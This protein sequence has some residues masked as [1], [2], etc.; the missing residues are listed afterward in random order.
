MQV[1]IVNVNKNVTVN[2]GPNAGN[3][4]NNVIVETNIA[5]V[6]AQDVVEISNQA[7]QA[8]QTNQVNRANRFSADISRMREIWTEHDREVQNFRRL[9]Q[10]L[11]G[12]QAE[13]A[14]NAWGNWNFNNPNDMVEISAEVQEAAQEAISEGG[15]WSVENTAARLLDFAVAISGGDPSRLNVLRNAVERGFEAAERQWGGEL[16]EIS[17][18]TR[19]AVMQG[20]D[21][22]Q[23]N[24]RASDI[25]LLQTPP[26]LAVTLP[27]EI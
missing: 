18:R 22:W 27:G 13:Q 20:F 24:G 12:Q 17:Q 6:N 23:A 5:A 15:F 4:N 8:N 16:P 1:N 10:D 9:I 7:S 25:T 26:A 11:L 19:E 3:G 14:N 2:N 21:E